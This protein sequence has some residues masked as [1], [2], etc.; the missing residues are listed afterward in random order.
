MRLGFLKNQLKIQCNLLATLLLSIYYLVSPLP[1][2]SRQNK[3][4]SGI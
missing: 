1:K 2:P 4:L 3:L